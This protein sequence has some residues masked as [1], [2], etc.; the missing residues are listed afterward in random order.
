MDV[1]MTVAEDSLR[2]VES[3][4]GV[5]VGSEEQ[6]SLF[7]Y[8]KFFVQRFIADIIFFSLHD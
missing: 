5:A 1:A 3:P 2:L 7:D 8:I 4:F 6:E